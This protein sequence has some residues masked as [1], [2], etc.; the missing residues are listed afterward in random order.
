MGLDLYLEKRTSVR[1]SELSENRF[2]VSAIHVT[3]N[4]FDKIAE[5]ENIVAIVEEIA[6]WRNGW[7]VLEFLQGESGESNRA[8]YFQID[9]EVLYN[10]KDWAEEEGDEVTLKEIEKIDLKKDI[11][12]HNVDYYVRASW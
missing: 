6:Y 1:N 9:P 2:E 12:N 11:K 5:P 8:N 7:E 3:P 10:L 4:G